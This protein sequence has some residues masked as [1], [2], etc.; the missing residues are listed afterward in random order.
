MLPQNEESEITLPQNEVM[1]PQNEVSE[2]TLSQNE[3]MLPQNKV[4]LGQIKCLKSEILFKRV[5]NI[6]SKLNLVM[7]QSVKIF[8]K[9]MLPI[10]HGGKAFSWAIRIAPE[11]F[12]NVLKMYVSLLAENQVSIR[13]RC[14][15]TALFLKRSFFRKHDFSAMVN[16][17]VHSVQRSLIYSNSSWG[18]IFTCRKSFSHESLKMPSTYK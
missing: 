12:Q 1:L 16:K 3:V 18:S 9:L 4:I 15:L 5:Q 14:R 7:T 2:I 10:M 6:L 13:F 11:C 17:L 8:R